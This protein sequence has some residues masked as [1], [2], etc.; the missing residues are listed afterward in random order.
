MNQRVVKSEISNKT[1]PHSFYI[2]VYKEVE[3]NLVHNMGHNLH[4]PHLL[5][6]PL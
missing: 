3:L 2:V 5:Q 1:N 4:P 6:Q